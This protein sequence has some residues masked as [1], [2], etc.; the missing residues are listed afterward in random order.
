MR[1][2]QFFN[3]SFTKIN[4][5]NGDCAIER[6]LV[7]IHD[8]ALE[9]KREREREREREKGAKGKQEASP[10]AGWNL[11]FSKKSGGQVATT[12]VLS[13]SSLLGQ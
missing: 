3:F 12:I 4:L 7:W 6:D 1:I 10:Q 11:I 13:S 8:Q 9:R 2:E 5:E